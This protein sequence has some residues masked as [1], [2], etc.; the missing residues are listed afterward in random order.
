MKIQMTISEALT[1]AEALYNNAK[2]RELTKQEVA[3]II[4]AQTVRAAMH[5][6]Y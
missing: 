3:L 4:L 1:I 6:L 5:Y 2:K